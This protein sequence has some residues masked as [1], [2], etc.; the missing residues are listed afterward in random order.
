MAETDITDLRTL[1]YSWYNSNSIHPTLIILTHRKGKSSPMTEN[2]E[3]RL[4]RDLGNTSSNSTQ[5]AQPR[6]VL[7][8][9]EFGE[10]FHC[11]RSH[12][13]TLIKKGVITPIP[14]GGKRLIPR[15]V[16]EQLLSG[17]VAG[18]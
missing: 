7:T 13:N 12:V 9:R 3:N 4:I 16:A 17:A 5:V 1:L 8:Y 11:S 18:Q 10:M 15:V 2:F 6:P 14:L